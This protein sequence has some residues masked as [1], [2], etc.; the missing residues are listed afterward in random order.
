MIT[1]AVERLA[2]SPQEAA[3]AVGLSASTIY[4][5]LKAGNIGYVKYNRR[6]LIS[7]TNLEAFLTQETNKRQEYLDRIKLP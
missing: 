1:K 6:I 3:V 7:R 4:R 2:Y 5:V